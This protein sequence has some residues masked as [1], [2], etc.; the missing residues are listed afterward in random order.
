MVTVRPTLP[1]PFSEGFEITCTSCVLTNPIASESGSDVS[2]VS[3]V[4][5]GSRLYRGIPP[6]PSAPDPG[7][8]LRV[9][10][11]QGTGYAGAGT[12][13]RGVALHLGALETFSTHLPIKAGQLIGLGKVRFLRRGAKGARAWVG[14]QAPAPQT[15]LPAGGSVELTMGAKRRRPPWTYSKRRS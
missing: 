9:L 11:P 1:R 2:P 5:L 3:G 15:A 8:R 4:I 14:S 13:G 10:A 12:S 6:E 7:Y